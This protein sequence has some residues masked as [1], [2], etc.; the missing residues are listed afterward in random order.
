MKRNQFK[1]HY[2][3][4]DGKVIDHSQEGISFYLMNLLNGREYTAN[5]KTDNMDKV[6]QDA[7]KDWIIRSRW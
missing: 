6:Q 3:T 2:M 7:L 1:M 5:Y 4:Q